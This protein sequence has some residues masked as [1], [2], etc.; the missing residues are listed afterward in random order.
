M[1]IEVAAI[2]I[3]AVVKTSKWL[4][5][6]LAVLDETIEDSQKSPYVPDSREVELVIRPKIGMIVLVSTFRWTCKL[7]DFF[8]AR[9]LGSKVH[10]STKKY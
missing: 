3:S 9:I 1:S 6:G 4:D 7:S 5:F 8:R 10:R 2:L